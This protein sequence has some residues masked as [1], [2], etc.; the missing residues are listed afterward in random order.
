MGTDH[1]NPPILIQNPDGHRLL[2]GTTKS[3]VILPV[4]NASHALVQQRHLLCV[5]KYR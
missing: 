4:E 2:S 1:D 3:T 5:Y